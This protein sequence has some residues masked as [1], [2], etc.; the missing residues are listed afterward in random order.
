[1]RGI[2]GRL[3][4]VL[5]AALVGGCAAVLVRAGDEYQPESAYIYGRFLLDSEDHTGMAFSIRCRD[6]KRYK[7]VFSKN[8]DE[9]LRMIRLPAGVCQLDEVVAKGA[10]S[11]RDMA[12]FRL[13]NN[14]HLQPGGVYYVGD[15]VATASSKYMGLTFD[16][17][18]LA[19]YRT[20]HDRWGLD[21]PR[22]NYLTTTADMKRAFPKFSA[23]T[24]V[25]RMARQ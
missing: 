12:P 2:R 13:L 19:L 14:E 1:M 21:L 17:R 5:A 23:V 24:T 22:N 3:T 9:S 16:A 4:I 18:T 6:G 25:D 15:F 7:I 10:A 8:D 20:W 11:H